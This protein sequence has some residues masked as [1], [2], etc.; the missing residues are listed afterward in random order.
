MPEFPDYPENPAWPRE[1]VISFCIAAADEIGLPRRVALALVYSEA[2]FRTNAKRY[3]FRNTM[4]SHVNVTKECEEAIAN[5]DYANLQY[6]LDSITAW[7]SNDI[8]FGP[9]QQTVRWA[10][11]GD[12]TQSVENV[13]YIR[14]LYTNPEHA[15]KVMMKKIKGYYTN[16][17]DDLE[18]LCR[19]NKP[20]IQGI[21]NPNR[22]NYM[23]GL[24]EADRI[25]AA[26]QPAP[27]PLPTDM[28]VIQKRTGHIAGT[29]SGV[30]KGFILHGSRSG[31]AGN[32]KAREALGCANWCVNN[33]DGLAWHASIG[34]NEYYVH[35]NANQWGWN[36]RGVSDEYVAVEF[37]Q[38]TEAE[39]IT[40]AQVNA[41]VHWA[42]TVVLPVYPNIP[43]VLVTHAEVDGT[44]AYGGQFDGKTDV[45]RKTDPRSQQLKDRILAQL[46][47]PEPVP[48]PGQYAYQ[49]GFL[50]KANELGL[51]V[52]GNPI[53][54]ETYISPEFSMQFT[55]NG[56]MMYSKEAN[57]VHF[58][59]A[60][61]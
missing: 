15:L 39:D 57:K 42:Q 19:Y 30:P 13:L 59:K 53:S 4:G 54:N 23:N 17:A 48:T 32:S 36:A 52:V 26:M 41:F 38:A 55:E 56:V 12:H 46:G 35:M 27:T 50:D 28:R 25:L 60:L 45:F 49:F 29:F 5:K 51:S 37:A 16:Y 22:A 10:D 40:D 11:E 7:G 14:N 18:A 44:A 3:A 9:G 6:Y 8:S 47:T 20:A 61:Q 21:N 43:L 31:A 33:P 2:G 58:F 24:A 1:D 34:E